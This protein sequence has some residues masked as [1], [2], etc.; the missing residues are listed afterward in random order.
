[1]PWRDATQ[2][3]NLLIHGY[4]AVKTHILCRTIREDFPG[5]IDHLREALAAENN[6]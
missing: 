5:L 1:V 3:R 6:E 2:T 4:D